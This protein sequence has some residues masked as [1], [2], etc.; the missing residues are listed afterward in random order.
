MLRVSFILMSFPTDKKICIFD[1][2][3]TAHSHKELYSSF[4]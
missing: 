4:S 3:S 2:Q 1:F